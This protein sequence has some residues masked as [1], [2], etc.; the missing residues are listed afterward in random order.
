M[1]WDSSNGRR[2]LTLPRRTELDANPGVASVTFSP[3]GKRLATSVGKT[4]RIWNADTGQEILSL[5]SREGFVTRLA[6]NPDGSRLAAASRN[7]SVMVWDTVTGE[8]CL[9]LRGRTGIVHGVAYSPDGRRLVTAAGGTNKGGEHLFSD[10]KLWDARTG[11]EILTLRGPLAQQPRVAF[12]RGGRRL[13]ASGDREVMIWEG[14]PLDEELVIERQAAS[15]VKFLLTELQTPQA[16]SARV[17]DYAVSDAVRQRALTL[18]EPV[19]RTQVRE[20]AENV[21]KSLSYKALFRSEILAHLRADPVLGEP[22]RHEALALAERFGESPFYHNRASRAVASRPGAGAAAYG[23]A[24]QQAEIACRLLPFEG[25]Y[26][27]TLGMAQYR[28]GR[29]QEALATLTSANELNQAAQGSPVAADLAFL[30]MCDY[31]MR[32]FDRAQ[33]SLNR[34]RETMQEPNS[35]RDAEAQSLQKEAEALL[36]GQA[37]SRAR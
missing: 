36:A 27:T 35:N 21:V 6:Y 10:V 14:I 5:R 33:A 7:G 3:S 18:V 13:A 16:V 8:T 23:R 4:V 26:Q 28:L 29:Y 20:E 34:L 9:T 32:Q 15:L 1:I 37:A 30:A 22:V 24:A 11:Q 2:V 12:D 25:P 19:W 31:Q 17:G